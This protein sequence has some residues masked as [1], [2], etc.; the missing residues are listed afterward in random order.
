M[1]DV[2]VDVRKTPE[3]RAKM[4][5]KHLDELNT[6]ALAAHKRFVL[7]A[8]GKISAEEANAISHELARLFAEKE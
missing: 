1:V 5:Q 8:N 6:R 4:V 2:F 3:Y 7:D